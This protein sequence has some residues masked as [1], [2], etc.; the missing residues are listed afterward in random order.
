MK[1]VFFASLL[2]MVVLNAQQYEPKW[3]DCE[4]DRERTELYYK[5]YPSK[6]GTL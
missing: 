5:R 3:S 4:N 2:H 6:Y 1:T